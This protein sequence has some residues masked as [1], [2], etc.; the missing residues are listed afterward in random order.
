MTQAWDFILASNQRSTFVYMFYTCS[1]Q[2]LHLWVYSVSCLCFMDWQFYWVSINHLLLTFWPFHQEA[3]NLS[4][5]KKKKRIWAII[6]FC[7]CS[8]NIETHF[9]GYNETCRSH[10]FEWDASNIYLENQNKCFLYLYWKCSV[11]WVWWNLCYLGCW[12]LLPWTDTNAEVSNRSEELLLK[13]ST[14]TN[15]FNVNMKNCVFLCVQRNKFKF[16]LKLLQP[17]F[18]FIAWIYL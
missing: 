12:P 7:A 9:A 14:N 6:I 2:H 18:F 17:N 5:K 8:P 13:E 11:C 15:T 4:L 1:S 3:L 10:H 16:W